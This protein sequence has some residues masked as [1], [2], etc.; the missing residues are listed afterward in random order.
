LCT[1]ARCC[2]PVPPEEI[3]GYI[4]KGRGVG[5]HRHD[6]KNFSNLYSRHPERFIEV[7]WLDPS[8][9]NY[10]TELVLQAYD[11]QGLLRDVSSV[12]ADE[13]VSIDS[14]QT[15]TDKQRM[16]ARMELKFLVPGLAALSSIIGKLEQL[17]NVTSVRR[18]S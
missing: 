12:L 2:R 13:K 6:C 3:V 8:E 16:E 11:R 15:S 5:I 1:L 9:E 18:K 14:I 10:A 17:P 4:T 7:D